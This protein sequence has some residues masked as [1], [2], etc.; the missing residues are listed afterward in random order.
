MTAPFTTTVSDFHAHADDHFARL[1]E[2]GM[3]EVL[4][5]DGKPQAV[6]LSPETYERLAKTPEYWD[7]VA[8]IRQ[9]L[10]EYEEGKGMPAKEALRALARQHGITLRG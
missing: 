1:R 3:V 5:Q 7:S 10:K 2:P 6:M 9:S 8:A 4:L